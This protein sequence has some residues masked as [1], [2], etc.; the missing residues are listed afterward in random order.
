MRGWLIGAAA[1]AAGASLL[2]GCKPAVEAPIDRGVCWH[3][4]PKQGGGYTFNK[5]S[6]N[7][8]SLEYCAAAL[9][10]MRENFVRM[11]GSHTEITGAYQGQFVYV[12]REGVFTASSLTSAPYLA[13]VRSGDGRLVVPGAMPQPR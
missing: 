13:L 11:G 1:A 2:A 9:E 8:P 7:L 5:L 4:V 12:R 3:M 10:K 6:E